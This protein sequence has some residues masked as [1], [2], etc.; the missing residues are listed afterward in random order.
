MAIGRGEAIITGVRC[1]PD[2]R[3]LSVAFPTLGNSHSNHPPFPFAG[4]LRMDA[5][6]SPADEAAHLRI[7]VVDDNRDA[8][9]V[10][11]TL[12][13]LWG[14]AVN[15]CYSGEDAIEAALPFQP[16]LMLVDLAMPI[17]SGFEVLRQIRRHP[18]LNCT[19]VAALTGYGTKAD[20]ER[21]KA[22]GFDFYLLK[23]ASAESLQDV[24]AASVREKAVFQ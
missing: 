16:D 3:I 17:V 14:H 22:A 18:E 23:P 6:R 4:V 7:L 9:Y 19:R 12:L 13:K 20:V 21:T 8:A 10:T 1:S 5:L 11:G 2:R 24:L 15:I